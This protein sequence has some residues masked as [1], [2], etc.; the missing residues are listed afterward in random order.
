MP[1][2][3]VLRHH[4]STLYQHVRS[5]RLFMDSG[6]I[7]I[8]IYIYTHTCLHTEVLSITSSHSPSP[9][10]VLSAP[11]SLRYEWIY[12][13][14]QL[15]HDYFAWHRE[16]FLFTAFDT[17]YHC[18]GKEAYVPVCCSSKSIPYHRN[19]VLNLTS[20]LAILACSSNTKWSTVYDIL[21]G[22]T[23]HEVLT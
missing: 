17:C 2:T 10:W 13:I 9:F 3:P 19:F 23:I 4:A 11:K 6:Y 18:V 22:M 8:D 21:A 20:V 5:G 1:E 16:Q 12:N 15:C 7:Y 14:K